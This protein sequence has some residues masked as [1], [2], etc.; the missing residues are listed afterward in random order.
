VAETA[1]QLAQAVLLNQTGCGQTDFAIP[2]KTPGMALGQLTTAA[3]DPVPAL[4]I[5]K[6]DA[7]NRTL[8]RLVKHRSE[9][10]RYA[11]K[12]APIGYQLMST[13]KAIG[14]AVPAVVRDA[15]QD[16]MESAL[17]NVPA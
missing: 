7:E 5:L 12:T 9:M 2:V 8:E 15:L 6:F 10:R 14:D 11:R 16:A 13:F 3:F 17:A 4:R 1:I